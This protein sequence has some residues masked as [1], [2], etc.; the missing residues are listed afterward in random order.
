MPKK[1]VRTSR[2]A[3]SK[4]PEP[5]SS[6]LPAA[7][8]SKA[9][10]TQQATNSPQEAV[11]PDTPERSPAKSFPIVGIGASAGGLEAFTAFL[12]ALPADTG[13][14]F[15]LVQHMDPKH[16]SM[17]H[18]LLAK[19]T[20]MP[21]SQVQD[22]MSVEPNRVYVIPPDTEMTIHD[23]VLKLVARPGGVARHTPIDTFLTSLAEDQGPKAIG[24]IL[25]GI[26]SDGTKGL[27]A[28][29]A[30]GASRSRRTKNRRA[31]RVCPSTP[32]R[33]AAWTWSCRQTSSPGKSHG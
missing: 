30:E 25:S 12:K 5:A 27:E 21:V 19:D 16:E 32:C 6:P 13:M 23:G 15:V 11:I 2:S 18:R 3:R 33:P 20:A 9:V 24:V 1:S 29:K 28:I 26:G 17:L 14:A 7:E 10:S 22:G 4:T 31:I 8:P